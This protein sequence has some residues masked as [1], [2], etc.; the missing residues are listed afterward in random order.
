MAEDAG[1]TKLNPPARTIDDGQSD[2]VASIDRPMSPGKRR[3]DTPGDRLARLTLQDP[4]AAEPAAAVA[5]EQ[6]NGGENGNDGLDIRASDSLEV[7]L[8][9][10]RSPT[11]TPTAAKPIGSPFGAAGRTHAHDTLPGTQALIALQSAMDPRVLEPTGGK[12]AVFSESGGSKGDDE[13]FPEEEE[14][15]EES[16]EVSGSD[17]DGSWI[18]WFCSLRGNEFFCEVDEDYIQV[19]I[20]D[21]CWLPADFLC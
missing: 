12:A 10:P 15:E 20:L 5:S 7:Q 9:Q 14:D 18:T 13:E 8:P 19:C 3:G 2:G 4:P 16:S 1:I 6:V 11:K 21:S 17:E